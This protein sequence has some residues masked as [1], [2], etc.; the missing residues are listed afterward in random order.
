LEV[1]LIVEREGVVK[2]KEFTEAE[3]DE[4][5]KAREKVEL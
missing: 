5:V 1:N 2:R 4:R 3:K